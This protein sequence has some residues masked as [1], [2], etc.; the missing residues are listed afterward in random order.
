VIPVCRRVVGVRRHV[1]CWPYP[2]LTLVQYPVI[3]IL[4]GFRIASGYDIIEYYT[5]DLS[6]S[7]LLLFPRV[8]LHQHAFSRANVFRAH[9][10]GI[11]SEGLPCSP[12]Q[13]CRSVCTG[14]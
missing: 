1:L 4:E 5:Q 14:L 12:K 7:Q 10:L 2:C 13:P 9:F 6:V 8:P 11:S 3:E